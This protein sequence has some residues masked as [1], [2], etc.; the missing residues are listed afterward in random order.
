MLLPGQSS[1][2]KI[3]L[4]QPELFVLDNRFQVTF[5]ENNTLVR[6]NVYYLKKD[7]IKEGSSKKHVK[8]FQQ[9]RCCY[10]NKI[11]LKLKKRSLNSS[12]LLLL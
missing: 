2:A 8:T 1:V 4:I 11:S 5:F 3:E 6:K 9:T 10:A 7:T 12:F